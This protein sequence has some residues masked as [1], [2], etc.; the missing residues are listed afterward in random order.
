MYFIVFYSVVYSHLLHSIGIFA[1]A[2]FMGFQTCAQSVVGPRDPNAASTSE[3]SNINQG[4]I[5][6]HFDDG[7]YYV[8]VQALNQVIFGG[9]GVL[10]L[11]HSTEYV[12]DTTPPVIPN[13]TLISYRESTNIS[14]FF[15]EAR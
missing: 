14:T 10:S 13:V 7:I 1:Y 6:Q 3:L 11:C 4:R 8:T 12:I 9:S 5:L 15:Y 2:W